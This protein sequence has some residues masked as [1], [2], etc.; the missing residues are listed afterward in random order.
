MARPLNTNSSC[1]IIPVFLKP[2]TF[3]RESRFFIFRVPLT[4]TFPKKPFL[5]T[6]GSEVNERE[7][8]S[9]REVLTIY[10]ELSWPNT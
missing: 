2:I 5:K 8:W 4:N 3:S 6:S 7:R 1:T 10:P 9:G